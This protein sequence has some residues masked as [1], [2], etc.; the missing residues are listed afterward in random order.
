MLMYGQEVNASRHSSQGTHTKKLIQTTLGNHKEG[1]T[2]KCRLQTVQ[3][4]CKMKIWLAL[5]SIGL[6]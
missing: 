3:A 1:D 2:E 4:V 6:A 5:I